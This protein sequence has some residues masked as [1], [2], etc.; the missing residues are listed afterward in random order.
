MVK[1]KRYSFL[2]N[3]GD[4]DAIKAEPSNICSDH[5]YGFNVFCILCVKSVTCTKAGSV[6]VS[7]KKLY[8]VFQG[9]K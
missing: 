8:I 9:S 4:F 2:E 6:D 1:K 7:V 5:F 3:K